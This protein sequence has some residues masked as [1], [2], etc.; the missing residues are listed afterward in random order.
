MVEAVPEQPEGLLRPAGLRSRR[1][2][3]HC[4]AT[5]I[6]DPR[7]FAKFSPVV[8][9]I[10][11]ACLAEQSI[12][13]DAMEVIDSLNDSSESPIEMVMALALW[14]A[15]REK[16]DQVC[17]I[18]NGRIYGR[19]DSKQVLT[20][21]PQANIDEYRV[22]FAL[23]LRS[24][25]QESLATPFPRCHFQHMVVECDGFNFHDRTRDQACRDRKR[26]RRLQTLGYL[27]FRYAGSEIW[28]DVF[29]CATEAIEVLLAHQ[30]GTSKVQIA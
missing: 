9:E 12:R 5:N 18:L 13:L 11:L 20:I 17:Y 25:V 23:T 3:F 19:T 30:S 14:I 22:D 27:V 21:E 24:P 15:G 16:I 26:D 28:A 6:V 10:F 2:D 7:G 4:Y 29:Q 1:D 8:A